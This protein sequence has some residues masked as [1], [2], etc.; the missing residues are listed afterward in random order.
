MG[1]GTVFELLRLY[2]YGQ[3]A[4]A[5]MYASTVNFNEA[6]SRYV[7]LYKKKSPDIWDRILD[8]TKVNIY[9]QWWFERNAKF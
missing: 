4:S 3:L 1:L 5:I 8:L 2:V 9:T 6:K 7:E